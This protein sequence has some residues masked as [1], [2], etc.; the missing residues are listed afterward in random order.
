M[1]A[2]GWARHCSLDGGVGQVGSYFTGGGGK[3]GQAGHY[4]AGGEGMPGCVLLYWWR[5][6]ARPGT[7]LMEEFGWELLI[8]CFFILIMSIISFM[9]HAFAVVS[10]FHFPTQVH[11][12]F[13][14]LSRRSFIVFCFTCIHF[15]LS[16]VK[17]I[18][19]VSRLFFYA[20]GCP[21]FS[22]PS[23]EKTIFAP[24]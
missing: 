3:Q 21:I 16:F 12:D 8:L 19:Y 24:L 17:G 15:E 20:C 18:K 10:T 13:F 4:S 6:W 1:G 11:L 5:G 23:V 7:Q 2:L 14:I 22:E 9:N